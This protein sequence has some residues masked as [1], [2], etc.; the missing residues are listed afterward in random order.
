MIA[1]G[2]SSGDSAVP[3]A[4]PAKKQ[5]RPIIPS[6][7][8]LIGSEHGDHTHSIAYIDAT[9]MHRIAASAD[10]TM[11]QW[12]WGGGEAVVFTSER[13]NVRHAYRM[14]IG[15]ETTRIGPQG[16]AQENPRVSPDGTRIVYEQYISQTD[17]DLGLHIANIDGS[18]ARRVT[19][20][21]PAG[22]TWGYA[23]PSFSP[24]GRWIAFAR[25]TD[26]EQG[27]AAIFIMR[28]GG[29]GLRQ[30]T[31]YNLDA[32][33]PRWSPDGQTILFTQ[34]G[35]IAQSELFTWPLW[36]V[37]VSGGPPTR[38]TRNQPGWAFNGDWSPDGS[39]IV[40]EYHEPGWDH[41]QLRIMSADGSTVRTLWT[42]PRG[43]TA[44]NPD[45]GP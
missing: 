18:K 34:R 32:S 14:R 4:A 26:F 5:A 17:Q 10:T 2:C 12:A 16:A 29:G 9:G 15:G 42:P 20:A 6:G 7:R 43:S 21:P 19:P 24:E 45:W 37:P 40:Y 25:V 23:D 36:I 1:A 8:I 39:Q 38:L 44:E 28:T 13:G 31:G 11:G 33:K 3:S 27:H 41:N 30:L 22:A 35:D